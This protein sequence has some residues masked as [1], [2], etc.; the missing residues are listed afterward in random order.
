M[1]EFLCRFRVNG[2]QTEERIK[3]MNPFDAKKIVEARYYGA[4]V[5]WIDAPRRV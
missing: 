4:N 3:A 5:S 2:M 1:N